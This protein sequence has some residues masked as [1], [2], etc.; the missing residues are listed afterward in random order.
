MAQPKAALEAYN[1]TL[2]S[3]LKLVEPDDPAIADVYDSIACS[4]TEMDNTPKALEILNKAREI[5]EAKDSSRMARTLAIFAMTY[6]RAKMPAKA[7]TALKDCWRLQNLT[8]EQIAQ[9]KYP[10]HSGDIVLLSRIHCVQ[11]NSASALQLASK[12]ITIRKGIL[13]DKGPRVADSMYIVAKMLRAEQKEASAA[14]L[15]REIVD[16]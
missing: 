7:L 9:S 10:K 1:E 12:S 13:G 16:M 8:E 15:L 14:K 11:G 6:L 4:Y 5:R 3:R 2:A